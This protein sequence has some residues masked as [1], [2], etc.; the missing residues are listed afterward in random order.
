MSQ[1]YTALDRAVP[2]IGLGAVTAMSFVGVRSIRAGPGDS[3]LS[4]WP[5]GGYEAVLIPLLGPLS[6]GGHVYLDWDDDGR[7]GS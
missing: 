7:S 5:R 2:L 6:A 4:L 1:K 3:F